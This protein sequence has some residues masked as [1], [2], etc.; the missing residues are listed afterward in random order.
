MAYFKGHRRNQRQSQMSYSCRGY[1]DKQ[2]LLMPFVC[3]YCPYKVVSDFDS[4]KSHLRRHSERYPRRRYLGQ[5]SSITIVRSKLSKRATCIHDSNVLPSNETILNHTKPYQC[6]YCDK[7][8]SSSS[9]K[10]KHE[11][12]HTKEKPYQ[13]AYCDKRFSQSNNKTIHERVNHTK[14]KPHQCAYCDKRFSQ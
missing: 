12:I 9:G 10:T 11:R 1:R 13:C 14:E 2:Q 3:K 8:F 4:Y 5:R 7:R 6:A